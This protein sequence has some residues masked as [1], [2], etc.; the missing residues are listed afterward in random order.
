[1]PHKDP[2]AKKEYHQKYHQKNKAHRNEMNKLWKKK[3]P[4][5]MQNYK[6]K[7]AKQIKTYELNR[8]YGMKLETYEHLE[9]IQNYSC[10][11]CKK[12]K[13]ELPRGLQVDHDH[14]TGHIRGLLCTKCNITLGHYE[15][16]DKEGFEKYLNKHKEKLN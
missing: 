13:D 7:Y 6:K 12:H 10:A 15:K 14:K 2:I 5:Y 11:I 9:K 16:C 1:M 3:N 8:K 4:Q